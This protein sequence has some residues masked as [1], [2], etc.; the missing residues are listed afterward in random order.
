MILKK[1]ES[2]QHPGPDPNLCA[3]KEDSMPK[4]VILIMVD[5]QRQ[6]M[7]SCYNP[8]TL[9]TPCLDRLAA[10]GVRCNQA[11]TCQ[12]VCGPARSAIFTGLYPHSNGVVAN[13]TPLGAT[14]K[15][16]GEW[17]SAAGIVC[18]YTG[19]WHLDGGDYFGYGR[20]PAGYVPA[21][22]YD[23]R[24]FL[25]EL[26]P[27]ERRLS[28]QDMSA[29]DDDPRE[30]DT[31]AH[32]CVD[33]A[34]RFVEEYRDRDFFYTLSLDEP[35]DPSV[36]PRRFFDLIRQKK[37][38]FRKSPNY[39]AS[40]RGKP[41]HHK[42]WARQFRGVSYET[43]CN[44]ME[45]LIAC[46]R[47]CDYE[48]GRFLDAVRQAGIE[49]LIFYT[50]DHGEM[51]LSH[52]LM[53]KGC[54]MYNE[55]TKVP[56]LISGGGFGTGVSEVPVSHIDLL[57]TVM[58]HLGCHI[59]RMLQGKPLQQVLANPD[60]PHDIFI[61]FTRYE[62]DHDGF[63]GYQPIRCICDG[64]Y[65]LVINLLSSDELYDLQEDPYEK[66]NL[67]RDDA[68]AAVRNALHDRL[69]EHMNV[70]RDNERGYWWACRPWRRDKT[71]SFRNDGYTRQ[72]IEE[73]F[74]Q[75]DYSTGLPMEGATRIK[76]PSTE[77]RAAKK[78]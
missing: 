78:K 42:V 2:K 29:R 23:M 51:A 64:R 40:L 31:Y 59:P 5:T 58:Q 16:A 60:T 38:R 25:E 46:N 33:R 41:S 76:Q 68:H 48:I 67:I 55:I 20:C 15:T 8:D 75:L 17:L 66:T 11:F 74:V 71:P 35:H 56:L 73:D 9:E 1:P 54:A 10:E 37:Y 13:C 50:S 4:Q 12:P 27:E 53:G 7:L 77:E 69:L 30:E 32:R 36:C 49:P 70:T 39:R 34:I 72:L 63:M 6:D 57:P 43:C 47:F 61:E 26:T 28:R 21:Y 65:K 22:W 24:C 62:T 44:Q 52:G 14:V 3:T 45:K 18:G 19:K